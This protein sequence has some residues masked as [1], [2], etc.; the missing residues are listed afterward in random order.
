MLQSLLKPLIKRG[1]LVAAANWQ[2]TLAQAT[3]DSLFKL[4]VATP[5]VGGALLVALVIGAEP[6]D[7]MSLEWREMATTIVS[8][9]MTHPLVLLS[10]LLSLG[11]V[12]IGGS[13]FV[14]LVKAGTIGV[15]VKGERQAGEIGT[16]PLHLE[17]VQR[18]QAFTPECYIE[19][20]QSLFGRYAILGA[21]LLVVY[22]AS[23]IGYLFVVLAA[24]VFEEAWGLA[25]LSTMGF[26]AWI[27]IVNLFYLLM[28]I[29]IA[30]EDCSVP[31]AARQVTAL[32]TR[33]HRRV[34]ALFAIVLAM[35]VMA[36]GVS[37][38]ATLALGVI[39][40]IPLIGFAVL[41]LQLL[42]WLFRGLLFQ[43][44]GL[45]SVGAYL[46]LYRE[47]CGEPRSGMLATVTPALSPAGPPAP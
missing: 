25:A 35:V 39:T 16:L 10:F 40:F 43:F 30:A 28:Q 47:V 6:R 33:A 42:A 11:I 19:A 32:L 21:V 18:A 5:I 41:P 1:V 17:D 15:L 14:F 44:L 24:G 31:I 27:T 45:S 46:R 7:L 8:S 37:V 9:L 3:A 22:A 29:V 26:V 34:A 4:M 20:A 23:G 2:V 13:L 36:T 38:A 12:M